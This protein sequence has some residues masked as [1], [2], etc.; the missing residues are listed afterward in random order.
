MNFRGNPQ[1]RFVIVYISILML[2]RLLIY[3]HSSIVVQ[4]DGYC[5]V[6]LQYCHCRLNSVFEN[7]GATLPEECDPT[8][9]RE[10]EAAALVHQIARFGK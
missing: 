6:K 8:L 4:A 7:S 3:S 2:L 5:G 9:L 10:E 1:Y